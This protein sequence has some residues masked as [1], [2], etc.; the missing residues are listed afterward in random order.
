MRF[1]VESNNF[2]GDIILDIPL[3]RAIAKQ[4]HQLEVIVGE[5]VSSMLAACSF[6]ETVH[7]KSRSWSARLMIYMDATRNGQCA[8]DPAHIVALRVGRTG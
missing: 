1:L 4:G 5:K 7:V 6:I 8:T 3:F 2:V